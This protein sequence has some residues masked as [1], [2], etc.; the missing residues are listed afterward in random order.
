MNKQL[1][2]HKTLRAHLNSKLLMARSSARHTIRDTLWDR[3]RLQLK[4]GQ[5]EAKVRD[6]YKIEEREEINGGVSTFVAELWKRI[7]VEK[8]EVSVDVNIKGTEGMEDLL[9]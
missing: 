8:I 2:N 7:D 5:D 3:H 1:F 6:G 9:K 4:P